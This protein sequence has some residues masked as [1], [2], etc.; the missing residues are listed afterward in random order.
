M[1]T[2]GT[3]VWFWSAALS[4]RFGIFA[5]AQGEKQ[6]QSGG[7]APH[8]KTPSVCFAPWREALL[9]FIRVIR[10]S[11]PCHRSLIRRPGVAAAED[12]AYSAEVE[13][14]PFRPS[15]ASPA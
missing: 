12:S 1:K 13:S 6:T 9:L 11:L 7:K 5:P 4:R 2:E 8:S 3:E 14:V 10:G 15:S